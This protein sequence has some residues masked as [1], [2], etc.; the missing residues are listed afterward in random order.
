MTFHHLN[1]TRKMC[2]LFLY[3]ISFSK[4]KYVD[5]FEKTFGKVG[6][7]Q[8]DTFKSIFQSNFRGKLANNDYLTEFE[9]TYRTSFEQLPRGNEAP[10]EETEEYPQYTDSNYGDLRSPGGYGDGQSSAPGYGT[11]NIYFN[12]A[13]TP[14]G[15]AQEF[16]TLGVG[17]PAD[18]G[19]LPLEGPVNGLEY[20][21][22]MTKISVPYDLD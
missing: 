18:D 6:L 7:G 16:G 8:E 12:P 9:K 4:V 13:G 22:F 20:S 10:S 15:E 17:A 21:E 19:R 1:R 2:Q 5:S 11:R 14:T 3:L